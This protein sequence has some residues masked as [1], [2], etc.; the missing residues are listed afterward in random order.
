[1]IIN[2]SAGGKRVSVMTVA[3]LS[4]LPAT[5]D[6]N[7]IAIVSSMT[8]GNVVAQYDTPASPSSGDVWG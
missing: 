7:T 6:E 2:M 3:S 8:Q 1:M 5:A 4:N